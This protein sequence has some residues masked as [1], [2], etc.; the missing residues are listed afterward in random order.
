MLPSLL[1]GFAVL[2]AIVL[3]LRWFATNTP[4]DVL[5]VLKWG[6]LI[7]VAGVTVLLVASGASA[8]PEAATDVH[9][10]GF[11]GGGRIGGKRNASNS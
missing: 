3:F 10:D 11:P 1:I 8:G 9:A 7:A 2:V 6:G 5:K 4:G